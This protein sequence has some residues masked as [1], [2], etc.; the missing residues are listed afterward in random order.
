[1]VQVGDRRMFAIGSNIPESLRNC[2]NEYA[3]H[4]LIISRTWSIKIGG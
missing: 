3:I 1:M 2:W 4:Q